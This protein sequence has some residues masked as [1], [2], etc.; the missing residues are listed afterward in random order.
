MVHRASSRAAWRTGPALW[1]PL[2]VRK[3][4]GLETTRSIPPAGRT[5]PQGAQVRFVEHHARL[6]AVGVD[7]AP[8][9][10]GGRRLKLDAVYRQLRAAIEEQQAQKADPC[11]QVTDLHAPFGAGE[12][13]QQEGIGA[14][15][16][17]LV[18]EQ[19][20][21]AAGCR[22]SQYSMARLLLSS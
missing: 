13:R 3:Y 9:H 20:A 15:L 18:A 6:E 22:V 12:V 16:D 7:V 21:V 5:P 2:P 8:E 19:K 11:P 14:R 4:G 10:G 1:P 17:E